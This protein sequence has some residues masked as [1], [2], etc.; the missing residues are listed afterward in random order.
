MSKSLFE[1]EA[2]RI[3]ALNKF[4][5]TPSLNATVIWQLILGI[6][7]SCLIFF[8]IFVPASVYFIW[9]H[10]F[11][12]SKLWGW[13][14]VPHGMP[15]LTLLQAAGIMAVV[16]LC[17]YRASAFPKKDDGEPADT[18]K[19]IAHFFGLLL[20]PWVSLLFGYIIHRLM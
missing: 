1:T 5:K 16:R 19:V 4:K 20:V 9:S 12:L 3:A 7:V 10:G 6:L 17:T 8:A 13:F 2:E 11:V 15:A 14:C 18:G